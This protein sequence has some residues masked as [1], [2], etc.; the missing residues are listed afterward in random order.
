MVFSCRL[1]SICLVTVVVV[2][3]VVIISLTPISS[4]AIN[5]LST[6]TATSRAALVTGASRVHADVGSKAG[7]AAVLTLGAPDTE[8]V[9]CVAALN[10]GARARDVG[11]AG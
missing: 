5:A 3:V 7:V 9:A 1:A 6:R 10:R 11:V 4:A 8:C 2:I